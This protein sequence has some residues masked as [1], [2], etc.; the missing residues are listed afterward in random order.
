MTVDNQQG[1]QPVVGIVLNLAVRIGHKV[2]LKTC[3]G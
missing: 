1:L 2:I 3:K